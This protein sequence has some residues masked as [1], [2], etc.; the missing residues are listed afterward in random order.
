MEQNPAPL[1]NGS[2]NLVRSPLQTT[3]TKI[4]LAEN[5]PRRSACGVDKEHDEMSRINCLENALRSRRRDSC[6]SIVGTLTI[7][8]QLLALRVREIEPTGFSP[9]EGPR[10][11]AT[12]RIDF[13]SRSNL[14]RKIL[15]I[16]TVS[17]AL[18]LL[19][20]VPPLS[21]SEP[22]TRPTGP[23]GLEAA[24]PVEP[25]Q[26]MRFAQDARGRDLKPPK[27][28]T[29]TKPGRLSGSLGQ[30]TSA[31]SRTSNRSTRNSKTTMPSFMSS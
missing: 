3:G 25:A 12:S 4:G 13:P 15:P 22:T 20:S 24:K 7:A 10:L 29:A 9:G 8:V 2:S 18:L 30:S 17:G 5:A 26:F 28:L 14:M 21:G 6:R 11:C 23:T 19:L 31:R 16:A 27:S 1:F